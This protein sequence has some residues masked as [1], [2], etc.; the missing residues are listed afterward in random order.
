[1]KEASPG[2]SELKNADEFCRRN[3]ERVC[4][5]VESLK[6]KG[7]KK[8]R[9][10][11]T[12]LDTPFKTEA[13]P[14]PLGMIVDQDEIKKALILAAA[15]PRMG[16]VVISGRRG[17][18][19]SVLAR[20]VHRLLPSHIERIKGN[21]YNIDPTAKDGIDSFL[22]SEL[23][24][25]GKTLEN[26]ETEFVQTPFVQIPLNVMEDS[27]IGTVDLERSLEA[28]KTLFSP[29]LLAKAHRGILYVDE[30]NLLDEEATNIL[31]NVMADG[32]VTV[33]REGLSVRY[34]CRP[35]LIATFN[36]EEGELRE[37]LLDRIAVSLSADVRPLTLE[38]RVTAVE[39]VLGFSGGTSD[40]FSSEADA[41]L[42]RATLEEMQL[43]DAIA[44]AQTMLPLVEIESSQILY[45]CEEATMAGCEG[46][47]A[48]IFATEVAKTCAAFSARKR[49]NADD[50]RT[51]VM[52]AIA[53]RGSYPIERPTSETEEMQTTAP[54]QPQ[55]R[56]QPPLPPPPQ[57]EDLSG[58]E[59]TED[60]DEGEDETT[61]EIEE[62]E[63]D[64]Q[65]EEAEQEEE[66][67]F[68]IPQE[69][70]FGV[71]ETPIDPK[72]MRFAKWTRR[73]KGGK[74]ARI[75]SYLRGKYVKPM[76][77]KGNKKGKI[78][79]G[80]TLR[81]AAPYQKSRRIHAHG[82]QKDGRL[83]YI[84]KADFRIKKM[85]RK[86]GSLVIF[87]VDA[88]GSMA[89]NRMNAAKGAALSLLAEA[90]KN[91]DKICL[92]AFHGEKAEVLVPPTKSMAL[93]K[94]RLEAM[95][96]GGGSPLAHGLM[97]AMR[98]GLNTLKI[99][100]DVGRVVIVCITDGRANI[101]M[102]ISVGDGFDPTVDPGSVD[103]MPSRKFLKDEIIMCSKKLAALPDFNLLCIDTEDKFVGTGL[104][105][106]LA[107]AALG[108][109]HHLDEASVAAITK[110]AQEAVRNA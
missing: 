58:N 102:C 41:A 30:I 77:P 48:E 26:M 96:C 54:A 27:L 51:A 37:H 44:A 84:D 59:Q 71:K 45:L 29:G 70:M 109:Y 108:N 23:Q 65:E 24:N 95:P 53:P 22:Q 86:A 75:F 1:M 36:P 20:S 79:V 78:A 90:Y 104:A 19:K 63:P 14:F 15:N 110:I 39:N 10:L 40:Q 61:A 92:I 11:L 91:R 52:L 16:G 106:E 17:T 62:E 103:G 28:G 34:P 38:E 8:P 25:M 3:S 12:E 7:M 81:A 101:P 57:D 98:M 93:T 83:V 56:Y 97:T 88:S 43:Q 47:R 82:T 55:A 31:L 99:K 66:A 89:L 67:T 5:P 35:L 50:L 100:M 94:S 18:G 2:F 49:V 74:Q 64:D 32:Y 9:S 6:A 107:R 13:R 42:K 85:A 60:E 68:E 76:F 87:L 105:Q 69:F 80:A 73:G 21:A 46:Q 72:L 4:G 33:E